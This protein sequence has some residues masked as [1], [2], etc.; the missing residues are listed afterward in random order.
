MTTTPFRI[1]GLLAARQFV[2]PQLV[3]EQIY[4]VSDDPEALISRAAQ[5]LY[6]MES[7]PYPENPEVD[8]NLISASLADRYPSCSNRPVERDT[9]Y[10]E[11][12]VGPQRGR[13]KDQFALPGREC[14]N[15]VRSFRPIESSRPVSG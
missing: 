7:G 9:E 5:E 13:P 4:F 10:R 2:S 8:A 6:D 1:E 15:L 3:G 14:P 11:M 12:S